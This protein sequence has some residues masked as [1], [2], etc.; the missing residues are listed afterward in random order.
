MLNYFEIRSNDADARSAETPLPDIRIATSKN[1]RVTISGHETGLCGDFLH[2][3]EQGRI[4]AVR[5]KL[6]FGL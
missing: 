1:A 6:R 4:T 5:H 2:L 3:F